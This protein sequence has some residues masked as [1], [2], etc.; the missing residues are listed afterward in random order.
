VSVLLRLILILFFSEKS[1]KSWGSTGVAKRIFLKTTKFVPPGEEIIVDYG[2]GYYGRHPFTDDQEW[3]QEVSNV[4]NDD[5]ISKRWSSKIESDTRLWIPGIDHTYFRVWVINFE[6]LL[7]KTKAVWLSNGT[8]HLL[9]F[10]TSL[11]M[12]SYDFVCKMF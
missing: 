10:K 8:K 5:S 7:P 6:G 9:C 4:T 12:I 2:V 1:T 3:S 11:R